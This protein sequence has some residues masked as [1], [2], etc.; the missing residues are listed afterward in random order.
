[1]GQ[2][3]EQLEEEW[4]GVQ[5]TVSEINWRR[6]KVVLANRSGGVHGV[7]VPG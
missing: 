5:V 3:G 2:K 1:M 7:N 4:H 6:R